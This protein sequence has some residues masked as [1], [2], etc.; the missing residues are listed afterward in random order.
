VLWKCDNSIKR[1]LILK[2]ENTK[3]KN[4]LKK[5][6]KKKKQSTIQMNSALWGDV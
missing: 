1:N 4:W 6:K 2:K 5:S 3:K